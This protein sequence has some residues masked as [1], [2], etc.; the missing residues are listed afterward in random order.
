MR[1]RH[2]DLILLLALDVL[3]TE[4]R[5]TRAAAKLRR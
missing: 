2:L 1:Y 5:V 4:R 3:L